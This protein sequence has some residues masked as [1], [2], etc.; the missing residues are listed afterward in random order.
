[1]E[2]N[3]KIE[4]LFRAA[5]DATPTERAKSNDLSIGFNQTDDTW[6]VIVKHTGNLSSLNE[7]YPNITVT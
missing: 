3:Q 1:M 2:N 5:L 7:K 4:T 6:E